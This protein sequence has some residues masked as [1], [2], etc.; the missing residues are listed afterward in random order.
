M[1]A[2]LIYNIYNLYKTDRHDSRHELLHPID[3]ATNHETSNDYKGVTSI[4]ESNLVRRRNYKI[5]CCI[6]MDKIFEDL[7]LY[8]LRRIITTPDMNLHIRSIQL[9]ITRHQMIIKVLLVYQNQIQY[10]DVTIK[11]FAVYTWTRF[12][13]TNTLI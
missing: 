11:Y 10:V 2:Y 8:N 12:S 13:M 3:L 5:L 7:C 4:L 6:Y 1:H 9:L